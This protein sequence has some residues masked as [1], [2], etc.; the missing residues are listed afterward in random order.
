MVEHRRG[1]DVGRRLDDRDLLGGVAETPY[2]S[3]AVS[4]TVKVPADVNVLTGSGP[5]PEEAG[6]V[7]QLQA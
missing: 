3:L 7:P 6:V 2:S 4:V 1:G 5:V